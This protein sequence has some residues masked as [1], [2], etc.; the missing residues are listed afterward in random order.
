MKK[1][2]LIATGLAVLST[3]AHATKARMAALGQDQTNGSEFISDSRNVFRNAAHVNSMKN[4]V[5]TEWGA[6]RAEDATAA[7][8]S[9]GGFFREAGAFAYGLYM[10]SHLNADR[11]VGRGA[12]YKDEQDGLD[13]FFAGDMGVEWGAKL[14]Y[15]KSSD[16][17]GAFKKEHSGLGLSAGIIMGD[18]EFYVS[19]T[20]NDESK[21]GAAAGDKLEGD[22]LLVGGSYS[23]GKYTFFANYETNAKDDTVSGTKT[24]VDETTLKVGVGHTHEVNATSR[25]FTSATYTNEKTKNKPAA[26]TDNDKS[27]LPVVVGFEAD[28][29]SWLTLRGSIAQNVILAS[30]KT[31]NPKKKRTVANSTDVAAGATLNFGKLKVD[32]TIGTMN[33]SGSTASE[34][35]T[36]RTDSLLTQVAV[37]Y[38]F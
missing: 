5:V 28:A 35:G 18:M 30:E 20:L 16:E 8:N 12:T 33:N 11:N 38:W 34:D 21:G 31:G 3:G 36:L 32:G 17:T 10:G 6:T 22:D 15:S 27:R 13:L 2:V 4:Y 26:A 23:M 7:N 19:K 25:V 29:T 37:H 9:E 14:H 24:E 1:H